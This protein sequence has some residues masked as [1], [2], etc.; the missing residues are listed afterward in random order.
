MK[1]SM[2]LQITVLEYG[3]FPHFEAS[4]RHQSSRFSILSPAPS[5]T[6]AVV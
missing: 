6:A 2:S 1:K 5:V 3:I 4:H